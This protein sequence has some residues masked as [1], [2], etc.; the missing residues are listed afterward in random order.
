MAAPTRH[1]LRELMEINSSN[2]YNVNDPYLINVKVL[3]V[4]SCNI[5]TFIQK[6][7][8]NKPG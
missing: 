7:L 1:E 2:H 4:I 5:F 6:A 3:N 8:T